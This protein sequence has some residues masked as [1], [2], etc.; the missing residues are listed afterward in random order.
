MSKK[1]IQKN[2]SNKNPNNTTNLDISTIQLIF[3]IK[4]AESLKDILE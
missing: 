2:T 1:K 4:K 3:K